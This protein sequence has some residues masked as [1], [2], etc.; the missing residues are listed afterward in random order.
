VLSNNQ[1][2]DYNVFH[3]CLAAEYGRLSTKRVR[4]ALR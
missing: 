1:L 3:I 4:R 2:C